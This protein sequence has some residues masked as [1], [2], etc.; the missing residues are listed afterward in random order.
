MA[1]L[2]QEWLKAVQERAYGNDP[3]GFRE[4]VRELLREVS[5]LRL[6][7]QQLR[8][9]GRKLESAKDVLI[10]LDRA[11][12]D[13]D[14]KSLLHTRSLEVIRNVLSDNAALA[15]ATT[16]AIQQAKVARGKVGENRN[17]LLVT[18]LTTKGQAFEVYADHEPTPEKLKSLD[19]LLVQWASGSQPLLLDQSLRVVAV[20]AQ[21]AKQTKATA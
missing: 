17:T 8:G 12:R 20:V 19:T 21:A 10:A 2:T 14:Q 3:A 6:E 7:S 18:V 15:D 1:M 13:I 16:D 9:D 4:E 5:I 11:N